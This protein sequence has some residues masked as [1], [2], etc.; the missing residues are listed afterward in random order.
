LAADNALMIYA[1]ASNGPPQQSGPF[2]FRLRTLLVGVSV[3]CAVA[4]LL[5]GYLYR[6]V[7]MS[8][9]AEMTHHAYV[10]TLHALTKYAQDTGKWP[11]SW[12]EL[13]AADRGSTRRLYNWPEGMA[14]LQSRVKVRFELNLDDIAAMTPQTFSAVEQLD[15]HYPIEEDLIADLLKAARNEQAA[16]K[17][18]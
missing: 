2:Q 12:H 5:A 6:G 3:F 14:D 11:K 15:P 9:D 4:G 18:R 16:T 17:V 1:Q 7:S 10:G 8:L 13:V